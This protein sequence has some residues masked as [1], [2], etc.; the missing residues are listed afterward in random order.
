MF[1]CK[2][3][4][5]KSVVCLQEYKGVTYTYDRV[6]CNINHSLHGLVINPLCMK[7]VNTKHGFQSQ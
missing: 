4:A 7:N 6:G 3:E 1:E 2:L 5:A